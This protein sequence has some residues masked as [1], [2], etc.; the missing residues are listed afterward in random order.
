[1]EQ[2]PP[3]IAAT[4]CLLTHNSEKTLAAAL[5]SGE[6]FDEIILC[7]G[8]ST[9]ATRTIAQAHRAT[10]IDQDKA[11]LDAAG[12]LCDFAGA[13]NQ[14]IQA[15]THR[16]VFFLD[17]DELLTP[18]L[19]E[20]IA[21][22]VAADIPSAWH[23][24]RRYLWQGREI[25]YS[26]T[27]PNKQMRFF[28]K[29]CVNGYIRRVHERPDPKPGALI[30]TTTQAMLVPFGTLP[31]LQRKW[32]Q[33]I[34]IEAGLRPQLTWQKWLRIFVFHFKV[35]ILYLLRLIPLLF[36]PLHT[37]LP[38]RIEVARHEYHFWLLQRLAKNVTL[39]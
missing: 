18:E 2:A 24:L 10:V 1:M 13:R 15:A 39:R 31:E 33:Y 38:I 37:R 20:E 22:I 23:V 8:A 35:S 6:R 19:V 16:W 21:M 4:L 9:D 32:R 14:L 5:S 7:D 34:E 30:R 29:S 12:K 11:F 3:R 28:E 25:L 26:T 27:Y 36:R 17:S